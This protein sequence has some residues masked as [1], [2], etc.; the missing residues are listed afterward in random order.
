MRELCPQVQNIRYYFDQDWTGDWA[1]YFN[2]V[3]A[4]EVSTGPM[5]REIS[6]QVT[7]RISDRINIPEL[8]MMPHFSFRSISEQAELKDPAWAPLA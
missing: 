7:W 5:L 2:V 3:L 8:G 4:D 1:V 6:K